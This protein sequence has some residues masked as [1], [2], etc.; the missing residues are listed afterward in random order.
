MVVELIR[1]QLDG[2]REAVKRG[3]TTIPSTADIVSSVVCAVEQSLAIDNHRVLCA[4]ASLL[5]TSSG[6]APLAPPALAGLSD[7]LAGHLAPQWYVHDDSLITR[8]SSAECALFV[9][10][11]AGALLLAIAARAAGHEVVVA[12]SH[13]A[14]IDED[15][16]V[17][18]VL[19]TTGSTIV[20]VGC[21]NRVHLKDYRKA[22]SQRT[23][24]ILWVHRPNYDTVGFAS[25]PTSA[26]LAQLAIEVNVPL[27]VDEGLGC[28]ADLLQFGHKK[29][30]TVQE[31]LRNGADLVT[32]STDKL[33]GGPQGGV[34]VGTADAIDRL[35]QHPFYRCLRMDTVRRHLLE[36]T[37]LLFLEP[38]RLKE[39]H[40]LYRSISMSAAEVSAACHRV[41][42][43]LHG[44]TTEFVIEVREQQLPQSG[45]LSRYLTTDVPVV[46][47]DLTTKERT[48][49]VVDRLAASKPSITCWSSEQ[50]V[51][52]DV[53]A[54][55][56]GEEAA[57]ADAIARVLQYTSPDEEQDEA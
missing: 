7:E 22:L 46:A 43:A 24:A 55:L 11:G 6:R 33:I 35:T 4:T 51:Y 13:L 29:T 53:R 49:D 40:P 23:R 14:T 31:H 54:L 38:E 8:L 15:F 16:N 57:L 1:T 30:P 37:L 25:E 3:M 41:T 47:L 28:F 48:C 39:C 12:S 36:K 32:F 19:E 5:S 56:P 17:R 45:L 42:E 20:E 18:D 50:T 44:L 21:T 34:I 9:N 26:E 27:I 2:I 10:N 52:F